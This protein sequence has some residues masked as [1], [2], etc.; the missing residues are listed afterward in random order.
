MIRLRKYGGFLVA[1]LLLTLLAQ[2][3]VSLLVRTHRMRGYLIAHL[4]SAFGRPV[5]AGQFAVQILPIPE[6]E[7]EA[8]T[9]GEDPSFGNEYFLR[10]D[11][12]TA[13][14]RWFGLL[15]GRL[16]FGTMSFSHPSLILVRNAA[17]RWNLEGWLPPAKPAVA[18]TGTPPPQSRAESTY[19]LQNIDFDEGRINFKVGNDK[20]PFAFTDVS[21]SVEQVS[22]GRWQVQLEAQPWRTGVPLQSTGTVYVK[23]YVAGTS[24]RLQPAQIQVHWEKVSIADVFRL[25]TGNDSGVRG[26]LA[27]DGNASIGMDET[28]PDAVAG[29]WRFRL[30]AR[31]TNIHRWDLTERDD[32]PRVN[33]NLKGVWELAS[34]E[35][36][37]EEVRVDLPKSNLA[38][39][40]ALR[41]SGSGD[42]NVN[43]E[44]VA[45]QGEDL[46][47]WYRA[48]EPDI[49]EEVALTEQIGGS[50]AASGWP[51]RWETG[52]LEGSAGSLRLPGQ[53]VAR[54]EP[55]HGSIRNGKIELEHFRLNL[56]S[57]A[58]AENAKEKASKTATKPHA[59]VVADNFIDAALLHDSATH[60]G[61]LR[62]NLHLTQ[63]TPVFKLTAAFGRPLNKGWEYS[64]V[65]SGLVTWNWGAGLNDVRR[66]GS[67]ELT[68]ARLQVAGL[69]EPLM[70]DD[71]RLEWKD[72]ARNATLSKVD[73]FGALWT[74]TISQAKR[75]DSDN[76]WK[77]QLHADHLDATE[78]DHWIGP[79]SRP[80]WLQRLLPSLLGDTNP[81]RASELLRRISAEGELTTDTLTI[82]KIKLAKA[83]ATVGLHSLRLDVRDAEAQWAGG[84]IRGG[85]Q[86]AFSPHPVY[87][88]HGDFANINMAQLP[89]SPRWSE[90]WSGL[91]NGT[92]HL[93]T[94]G[95]GR[96]ELLKQL[97]GGGEVK[98]SKV[99]FRGWDIELSTQSGGPSAGA[100][101]WTTGEGEF[102]LVDQQ[103][104]LD[105]FRL[106][107]PH[108]R[109]QLA[110]TIS[111]GMDG[112]LTFTPKP[113]PPVGTR[114]V[115]EARELRVTGQLEN[116]AVNVAPASSEQA[117]P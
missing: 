116:P 32:N 27:V 72:G 53:V 76:N 52:T 105:D 108:Q 20:R 34:D 29:A 28:A 3:G 67:L 93:T 42:W 96:A 2:A 43:F 79:R 113:R 44:N 56:P 89:W 71:A 51:L 107:A 16:E 48:F 66:N 115:S 57:D 30:Q 38:G 114:T 69:N 61:N 26:Q 117:R 31:A 55:F 63:V 25:I 68:K 64:G 65:A 47:A 74:G 103:V 85:M 10:A 81:A 17:G 73:A 35:A 15:R 102:Q 95:V 104:R 4:E 99:E 83:H 92:I 41:T 70:L 97:A 106:D 18:R 37:A 84:T 36:R 94:N 54:L 111:F 7:L 9:I 110:G 21:G 24:A 98:V 5:Q 88:L 12:M 91:A 59:P 80:N 50:L 45:V 75:D 49:S 23:G 13:R 77:F 112:N 33:V 100:S 14:F 109:T 62:L 22:P 87:E 19:H 46:L 90:R 60:Q 1:I 82:E 101:R 40:G 58:P 39:T 8:V 78:L 11:A 6:L 86:L